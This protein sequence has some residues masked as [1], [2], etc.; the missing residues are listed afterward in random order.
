M[1]LQVLA[2]MPL[3]RLDLKGCHNLRDVALK[4]LKGAPLTILDMSGSQQKWVGSGL[5]HLKGAPLKQLALGRW[6]K[7]QVRFAA[8]AS[9]RIFGS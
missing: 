7:L 2:G 8:F 4:H 5:K 6:H 9:N 1:L 3:Q